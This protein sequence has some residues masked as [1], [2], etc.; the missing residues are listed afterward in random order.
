[1]SGN[2]ESRPWDRLTEE[3][4]QAHAAFKAYRDLG[5]KRSFIGAARLLGR[6]AS[7]FYRW[8]KRF[9]W[10]HRAWQWDL[11]QS[12]EEEA[13]LREKWEETRRGELHN[14]DQIERITMGKLASLVRRDSVTGELTLDP[15]MTVG[16]AV[17]LY[18][19]VREI[20]RDAAPPP[21]SQSPP[22][23]APSFLSDL[24]LQELIRLVKER[25]GQQTSPNQEETHH[26]QPPSE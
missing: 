1:M 3:S 4:E 11:A 7:Q 14:A 2:T 18:R 19:L 13:A 10:R 22:Q 23:A 5:G 12:R 16:E 15:S 17:Q 24:E 8:A 9:D 25:A 26:A 6:C 21:E 20:R